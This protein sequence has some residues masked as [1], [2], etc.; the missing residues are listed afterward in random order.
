MVHFILT[1]AVPCLS[2]CI[3]LLHVRAWLQ[4]DGTVLCLWVEQQVC[5][6][7]LL[8]TSL[9][10]PPSCLPSSTQVCA[11]DLYFV[12]GSLFVRTWTSLLSANNAKHTCSA[13]VQACWTEVRVGF[14]SWTKWFQL[15]S[16]LHVTPEF[17]VE[18]FM[19]VLCCDQNISTR[20]VVSYVDLHVLL[21]ATRHYI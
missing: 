13:F 6:L 18:R 10:S 1:A 19:L 12:Y 5:A 7:E 2:L 4:C 21:R 3:L 9:L 11:I 17:V 16:T 8:V 15:R 14:E 20:L